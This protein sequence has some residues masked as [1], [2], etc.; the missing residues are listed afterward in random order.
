MVEDSS[1]DMLNA[2]PE[3]QSLTAEVLELLFGLI[4]DFCTEE[5]RGEKSRIG[6]SGG[7]KY[8]KST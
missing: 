2:T 4:M 3:V 8:L 6:A 1:E 5:V 7:Q